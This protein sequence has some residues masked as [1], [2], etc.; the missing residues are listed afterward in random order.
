MAQWRYPDSYRDAKGFLHFFA[1]FCPE[2]SGVKKIW[3]RHRP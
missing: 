3:A 2:F 1:A